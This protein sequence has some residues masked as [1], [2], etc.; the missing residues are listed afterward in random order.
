MCPSVAQR[1]AHLA[2][3]SDGR[4]LNPRPVILQHGPH[5]LLDS[6]PLGHD[7]CMPREPGMLCDDNRVRTRDSI[8][9]AEFSNCTQGVEKGG[10]ATRVT[11]QIA[12]LSILDLRSLGVTARG[13]NM[14]DEDQPQLMRL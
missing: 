5:F 4:V 13:E 11:D 14:P 1:L 7:H 2:E 10:A 6:T 9:A 8:C 3:H 12:Q